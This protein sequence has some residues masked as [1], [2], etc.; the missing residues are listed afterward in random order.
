MLRKP[1]LDDVD[2]VLAFVG[3]DEV[4]RWTGG[5]PG[6]RDTAIETVARWIAR[7]ETNGVGQFAVVRDGRV[8]G[9]VGLLV[10]D[11]RSWATSSYASAGEHAVTELGW[12]LASSHWGKGLA[13]EAAQAV[14][15]W[16]YADRGIERLISLIDPRNVRSIRVADKLGAVPEALVM[17]DHGPALVWVH[18]HGQLPAR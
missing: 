16:A 7:W 10:W 12:A 18:P 6:G 13:T 8:I 1:R 17:T 15:V 11:K 3:D 2:D 5:E 9:R 14:R 4:M